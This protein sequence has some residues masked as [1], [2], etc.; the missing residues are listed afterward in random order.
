MADDFDLFAPEEP[1]N[2]AWKY[3]T[4]V[5]CN[6]LAS[7][8]EILNQYIKEIQH[9]S[10]QYNR[11]YQYFDELCIAD[12]IDELM[13]CNLNHLII[14][15]SHDLFFAYD[16]L[17]GT[18]QHFPLY[19]QEDWFKTCNCDN[20]TV[21]AAICFGSK[22]YV[23]VSHL[24]LSFSFKKHSWKLVATLE[25]ARL[26][27]TLLIRSVSEKN[28]VPDA[29]GQYNSLL[30]YGGYTVSMY[31]SE[32]CIKAHVVFS[33]D[34]ETRTEYFVDIACRFEYPCSVAHDYKVTVKRFKNLSLIHI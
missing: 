9:K 24:I 21:D 4:H 30:L 33:F 23:V 29:H 22:L 1:D 34:P 5:Q 19:A 6:H 26:G 27:R 3:V 8:K 18:W 11:Y 25:Q 13:I 28:S 20:P 31:S 17:R 7:N 10:V 32:D 14:F 15:I 16:L 2:D 12:V